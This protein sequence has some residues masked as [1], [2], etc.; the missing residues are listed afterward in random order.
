MHARGNG[1]THSMKTASRRSLG[2]LLCAALVGG[3]I[4]PET[5]RAAA[6]IVIGMA[7]ES[8]TAGSAAAGAV[9]SLRL[10][11]PALS[12]SLSPAASLAGA[13]LIS[14]PAA[15]AAPAAAPAL[16]AAPALA[17]SLPA[18]GPEASLAK[19]ETEKAQTPAAPSRSWLTR[20]ASLF[21]RRAAPAAAEAKP[22][23][24][25][26]EKAAADRTFDGAAAVAAAPDDIVAA[27]QG[28]R[29]RLNAG[30]QRFAARRVEAYKAK[31]AINHDEFGG[32]KSEGPTTFAGRVR[33][34]VKWGLNLVGI[35]A[36]LDFTLNPLLSHFAWPL[37][38]SP[39]SLAHFGR[40]EL[41]TKYGPTAIG[42]ALTHAPLAFLGVA[43]PMSTA[44]EEF[45]YRFLGFGLTFGAMAVAKPLAN[46]AANL[47]DKVPDAA[48]FRSTVQRVL[49]AAGGAVTFF[50]FPVAALTSSFNF[51]V[52]HFAQW[53]VDP[54]VFAL[55][56]VA[57]YFLARAAYKTRGLTAPFVAHMAFNLTMLGSAILGVTFGLPGIGA[58]YGVLASLVGV[59]TLWYNW[60]TA[61]QERTFSL[62]SLSG[63]A[64]SLLIAALISGSVLGGVNHGAAVKD[65]FATAR[66]QAY[67]QIMPKVSAEP[68]AV[69]PVARDAAPFHNDAD[70][71]AAVKPSVVEIIVKMPGGYAL[72]SGVIV[73]PSGLLV[74]NGH[75]VGNKS[76]GEIV[77]VKLA[78]DQKVPAKIMA[79]NH[80]RDLAILQLPTLMN[81]QTKQPVAWPF[82]RF[83]QAAPREGDPLFAMGHPLG[84]PFTVTKGIL[85]G[86]GYRGN[87]FVQ[88]LQTDAAITHGNSG[89]PI[90]N[91]RGE[92]VGINTMGPEVG[93]IGFSIMAPNVVQALGQYVATGNIAT[94][95]LGVIIDLSSPDQPE[96]GV[97]VEFVR[98]GSAA[99]K[100]GLRSGDLIVGVAGEVI[101]DGGKKAVHD[102]GTVLA[103]AKP[104]DEIALAV[105]RGDSDKPLIVKL[106]LDA[107]ATTEET[108]MAHDFDG[109]DQP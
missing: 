68:K 107:R 98:P 84:L 43:L 80:N 64:K 58:V 27:P 45:T 14:A 97:A 109:E 5:A 29:A 18:T 61:R 60:R 101:P 93:G 66:Y 28:R 74:T 91:A 9:S 70:M 26:A 51:A 47:L 106:K 103:Q 85:S 7:G 95:A 41:L 71:I 73:S 57:G 30:L 100:A 90:Y 72:G 3:L 40:V 76:V 96:I 104:G 55:N 59:A 75:V 24:A 36:I 12:L 54:T 78:N 25:S 33:Y 102:L 10:T 81:A 17:A 46:L 49:L 48:G 13:P 82:S 50:A 63:G 79:V 1:Y 37:L 83:A 19:G 39:S 15:F 42:S 2:L 22:E 16:P 105:M 52:A 38:L 20:A 67:D 34:G 86:L 77:E 8:G 62:K 4:P 89:G 23:S 32:P 35:S 6:P 11:A 53:G 94:A 21:T 56:M 92:V 88:Y 31:R 108:S 87:M 65:S 44:M 99:A 69:A